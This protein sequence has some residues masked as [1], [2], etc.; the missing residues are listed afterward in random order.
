MLSDANIIIA[1][2]GRDAKK[3]RDAGLPCLHLS[4][5]IGENG[6]L[7]H[8][9]LPPSVKNDFLGISDY[10]YNG[11]Y[12]DAENFAKDL[13]YEAKRRGYSGVFADFEQQSPEILKLVNV[14]D[15]KL[16]DYKL[17][18]FV[19][20]K[21]GAYT[22]NAFVVA[23]TALSGGSLTEM[24]KEHQRRFGEKSIAAELVRVCADFVLPSTNSNGTPLSKKDF[25]ELLERHGSSIFF[26]RE[27]CAKYFTY[28]DEH[29]SGH[30]VLFDDSA[31]MEKK[32]SILDGMGIHYKFMVY[33]DAAE[34]FHI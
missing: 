21:L 1:A 2:T 34:L 22:S 14:L 28:M 19:P 6:T 30:F 20:S 24:L 13:L 23:E 31:T 9:M 33:P 32:L 15:R 10:N 25:D 3:V 11:S 12:I 7:L 27:L 26:S 8:R 4:Y 17:P 18:F 29:M 16:K 5:M